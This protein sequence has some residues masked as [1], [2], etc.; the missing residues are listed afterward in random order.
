MLLPL[1]CGRGGQ[2][3]ATENPLAVALSPVK[4]TVSSDLLPPAEGGA[5]H[6]VVGCAR[7]RDV[8]EEAHLEQVYVNGEQGQCL[9]TETT[10][11]GAGWLDFDADGHWDVYLNQG[12]DATV[13]ADAGQPSDKLFQNLG[14]GTFRDVTQKARIEEFHYSQAVAVG[15]YDNDGF[16][17]VYVTNVGRNTLYHNQGD[18]TFRDVT[19]EAGVG[20]RRWSTSAAWADLDLDG[21]LDLYVANYCVYDPKHPIL[22]R[23]K[24]GDLRTCH[25]RNVDAWPDECYFNQGDGTFSAEAK[26]RGLVGENGRGL[27]VAVAD[28][29]NDG[30]PDVYVTNDTTA[31]FLFVNQGK[32][33]FREMGMVSGCAV[34]VN[35]SGQAGMGVAV[36]D[37]DHNGYLDLYVC[38]F[39]RES[40]TLYCN[41][42]EDGFQDETGLLGLHLPTLERLTF[43]TVM[44]DFN[45]DGQ[46]DIVTTSGH[47][48][49]Y[50]GNPLYRMAPQMFTFDGDRWKECTEQ[51]GD[52]FKGKYVGRAIAACDY[53]EDGDLDLLVV[54]ENSPAALLRNVSQRGHWLEFFMRGRQSNCR[55]IG[56]RINVQAGP[57]AYMQELCGGTGYAATHQPALIFGLGDWQDPCTVTIR[58][59]SGRTQTLEDVAVDQTLVLDESQANGGGDKLP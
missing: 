47:I 36:A 40:N 37:F 30:L 3:Q 2:Q 45:Q 22:C 56:C 26:K 15:D 32:G 35:G 51:A 31:N 54:H 19:E 42:G 55:G 8:H 25:P 11:G 53:D 59:P 38:H 29:N 21:D 57:S 7:F 44:A 12:G 14:D 28:F 52:F 43:G 23:N 24:K 13:E 58:W 10:G 50:P 9:L 49:N 48:D 17:D 4:K 27:G 18:G 16:D 6:R 33:M 41:Y 1:G 46:M 39:Y 34:D 20:D 5:T